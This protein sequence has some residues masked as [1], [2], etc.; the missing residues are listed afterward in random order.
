[1][2]ERAN[3][4]LSKRKKIEGEKAIL[5]ASAACFTLAHCLSAMP[6]VSLLYC[7]TR[8][9]SPA[10]SPLLRT[11]NRIKGFASVYKPSMIWLLLA[12]SLYSGHSGLVA[13]SLSMP[14]SFLDQGLC[15]CCSIK[16]EHSSSRFFMRIYFFAKKKLNPGFRCSGT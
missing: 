3:W 12:L 6:S 14:H 10:S 5:P 11:K 9:T 8:V 15:T 13:F 16:P 7:P 2:L 1:M 4:W